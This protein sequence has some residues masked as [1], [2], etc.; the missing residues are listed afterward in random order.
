MKTINKTFTVLF[1]ALTSL[2]TLPGFIPKLN[3][4]NQNVV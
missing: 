1:L 4:N 2:I 3:G